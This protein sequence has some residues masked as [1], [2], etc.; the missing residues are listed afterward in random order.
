MSIYVCM[1][2]VHVMYIK[3]F[4]DTLHLKKILVMHTYMYMTCIYTYDGKYERIDQSLH[5][6][7][8]V[9][10]NTTHTILQHPTI[11]LLFHV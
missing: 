10:Y 2:C 4:I 7:I 6:A 5:I 3:I 8:E 11:V 1:K 9:E